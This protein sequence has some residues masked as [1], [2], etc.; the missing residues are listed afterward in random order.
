[1][2]KSLV[3]KICGYIFDLLTKTNNYEMERTKQGLR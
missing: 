3:D 2:C 1:M